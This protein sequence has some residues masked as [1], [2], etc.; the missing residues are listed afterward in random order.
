MDSETALKMTPVK[1]GRLD[2]NQRPL[3]PEDAIDIRANAIAKRSCSPKHKS[4]LSLR[5]LRNTCIFSGS[6]TVCKP[7]R[8]TG[9]AL[10]SVDAAHQI[11]ATRP[12]TA[13][14]REI[15]GYWGTC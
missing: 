7:I 2:L 4:Q 8:V 15:A 1:S 13:T 6:N 3:R 10:T 5:Q 12:K 14:K 9:V 11:A